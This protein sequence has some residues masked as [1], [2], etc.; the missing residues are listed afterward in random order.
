M[1]KRRSKPN[2][3]WIYTIRL[4]SHILLTIEKALTQ[5]WTGTWTSYT[6]HADRMI[7]ILKLLQIADA[8]E[9]KKNKKE[10]TN[11]IKKKGGRK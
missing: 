9:L 4:K 8:R 11:L 7:Y 3:C 5:P 1:K 6:R 10:Y 2:R